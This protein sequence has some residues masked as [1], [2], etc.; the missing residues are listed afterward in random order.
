M[1]AKKL[2]TFYHN[3]GRN[4]FVAK[5]E[6]L[7]KIYILG[8]DKDDREFLNEVFDGIRKDFRMLLASDRIELVWTRLELVSEYD[9]PS[10]AAHQIKSIVLDEIRHWAELRV[11]VILKPVL[12]KKREPVEVTLSKERKFLEERLKVA[13]EELERIKKKRDKIR[14]IIALQK[15]KKEDVSCLEEIENELDF[16]MSEFEE[17]VAWYRDQIE[18]LESIIEYKKRKKDS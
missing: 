16:D 17:L 2:K 5:I 15:V 13:Q 14:E 1:L 6:T 18:D 3:F 12:T 10:D 7:Q 11:T 8:L 9:L 4:N